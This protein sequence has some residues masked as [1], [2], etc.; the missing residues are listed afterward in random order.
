MLLQVVQSLIIGS[1]S[2]ESGFHRLRAVRRIARAVADA[3]AVVP[4]FSLVN[5]FLFIGLDIVFFAGD[6]LA[7]LLGPMTERAFSPASESPI[8]VPAACPAQAANGVVKT[9]AAV[10]AA[11]SPFL[12]PAF[13]AFLYEKYPVLTILAPMTAY[14]PSGRP[15]ATAAIA[16]PLIRTLVM[17]SGS[18][19]KLYFLP[20]A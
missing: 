2:M 7:V 1:V 16:A 8:C 3:V 13:F 10:I 15:Q 12:I 19:K 17:P 4:N 5:V 14:R 11:A 20:C 9:A 18:L 6:N